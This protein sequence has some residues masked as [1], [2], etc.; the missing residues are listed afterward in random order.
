MTL[1]D[2]AGLDG[3][4]PLGF[5]A[6][7]GLHRVVAERDSSARLSWTTD[8]VPIAQLES[9]L[10]PDE[11]I[12]AI[13]EDLEQRWRVSE[14]LSESLTDLKLDPR[15][16]RDYLHKCRGDGEPSS[17]FAGAVLAE[18]VVDNNGAS[19]P[20]D[21]HFT[22]GQQKWLVIARGIREAVDEPSLKSAVFGP[23]EYAGTVS[24]MSWDVLDDR[25]YALGAFDPSSG[26][27][28]SEPGADWLALCGL[29]S[30][31]S[32]A[33]G[34]RTKTTGCGG[35]WKSGY[36]R[37][38]L[39]S[40]ATTVDAVFSLIGADLGGAKVDH[41]RQLG[42]FAVMRSEIT[43]TDQG[44]YGSFGPPNFV[45]DLRAETD[46]SNGSTPSGADSFDHRR[47]TV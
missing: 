6:A 44:G 34:K 21:F 22:A 28:P 7:I 43:R 46:L 3:T 26:T 2:A 13:L 32:F 25:V 42:V 17:S 30:F 31:P 37:W 5:F 39:W 27:K 18:G 1:I 11:V 33:S 4:N 47:G 38:P 45:H 40:T 29:G 8:P 20:S 15:A 24:T 35:R 19:K 10:G 16:T 23:W 12:P 14:A 9:K 36:F 41:L